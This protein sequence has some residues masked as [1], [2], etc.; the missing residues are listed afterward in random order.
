VTSISSSC[1][2]WRHLLAGLLLAASAPTHAGEAAFSIGGKT[3]LVPV[4]EG[5]AAVSERVPEAHR[6]TQA[7]LPPSNRLVET[8]HTEANLEAIARGE[9]VTG[10]YFMIQTMRSL[11]PLQ[12][13][14]ADWKQM[15]PAITQGMVE[16]N[17]GKSIRDD[18]GARG[19]RMSEA[20]GREV[21]MRIGDI[22]AP[23]IYGRTPESIRFLMNI[24]ATFEV[25]G[26][27]T[28][29]NVGAAGAIILVQN[30]VLFVYWYAVPASPESVDVARRKL[31]ATADRMVAL[32]ASDPGVKSSRQLRGG[33]DWGKIATKGAIG[34]LGALLVMLVLGLV[35]RRKQAG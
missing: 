29:L 21:A 24:P 1:I 4:E 3:I 5:Y 26:E 18:E 32:N 8:F 9:S 22:K 11:E 10:H 19:T 7:A 14:V 16:S 23:E 2:E 35:R 13:S 6:F 15:Q 31:D 34:G 25:D 12:V 27:I 17:L 33:L 30:R 20:A 28:E